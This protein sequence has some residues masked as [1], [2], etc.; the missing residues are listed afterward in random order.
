MLFRTEIRQLARDSYSLRTVHPESA[1]KA[2]NQP[3]ELPNQADFAPAGAAGK[4]DRVAINLMTRASLF[5]T[6]FGVS[7]DV[8]GAVNGWMRPRVGRS[9]QNK[10]G[11]QV[12]VFGLSDRSFDRWCKSD[13]GHALMS[14]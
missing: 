11:H 13:S 5:A 9:H 3:P 7:V 6:S 1:A 2:G 4:R 10:I 8:T 12:A 14:A